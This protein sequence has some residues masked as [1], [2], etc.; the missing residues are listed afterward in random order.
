[1]VIFL[2]KP[3]QKV[4][5]MYR[6]LNH[7]PLD[8]R[9]DAMT[10]Q[11]QFLIQ[12][13]LTQ[14]GSGWVRSAIFGLGLA[15]ENFPLKSQIFLLF[16]LVVKKNLIESKS[17]WVKDGLACYLLLVKGMLGSGQSPSLNFSQNFK[18]T[19]LQFCMKTYSLNQSIYI[20]VTVCTYVLMSP[21]HARNARPIS[22]KFCTDLPT[23][24][25]KV[26]NTSMT[27]PTRPL[28]PRVPETPK[29]KWVTGEK[30]LCYGQCPDGFRK[31]TKFFLVA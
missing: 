31:L 11:L 8:S 18:A 25:W 17:T 19:D 15:L 23:N 4:V 13:F 2:A 7:K 10:T 30:T 1:M 27:P 29:S 14:F 6:S 28:D 21:F 24:S 5:W 26:L 9:N 12:I 20:K 16:A 22:T 3:R